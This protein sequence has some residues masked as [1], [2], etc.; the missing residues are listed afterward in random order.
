M[1][2][3]VFEKDLTQCNGDNTVTLFG[4]LYS[5]NFTKKCLVSNDGEVH[6]LD[7]SKDQLKNI[8]NFE[9]NSEIK[10]AWEFGR[11]T[12]LIDDFIQAERTTSKQNEK[13]SE[14]FIR[15]ENWL[16]V[17]SQKNSGYDY[18]M[19]NAVR[20]ISAIFI[21]HYVVRRCGNTSNILLDG[22][23]DLIR[24]LTIHV[25]LDTELSSQPGNH[26]HTQLLSIKLA[27]EFFGSKFLKWIVQ[28]YNK[29][30]INDIL[31]QFLDDG[32]SIEGSF[33]YNKFMVDVVLVDLNIFN[34]CWKIKIESNL[35]LREK[36]V[37]I[38]SFYNEFV[39]P[40]GNNLG[41]CD[42]SHL[43]PDSVGLDQLFI[44]SGFY[45]L[46]H[47]SV[48]EIKRIQRLPK[49]VV[50]DEFGVVKVSLSNPNLSLF[51]RLFSDSFYGKGGHARDDGMAIWLYVDNE[52]VVGTLGTP[53]YTG[54]LAKLKFYK[55]QE[56]QSRP[57]LENSLFCQTSGPWRMQN[58]THH[59]FDLNNDESSC[60][61]LTLS[62]VS[63]DGS[64]QVSRSVKLHE[65]NDYWSIYI[66]DTM[67]SLV[68]DNFRV[69]IHILNGFDI[70]DERNLQYNRKDIQV[71]NSVSI[72]FNDKV[73]SNI[74]PAQYYPSFQKAVPAQSIILSTPSVCKLRSSTIDWSIYVKKS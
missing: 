18:P 30:V 61:N 33:G 63:K 51:L 65:C 34:K 40:L 29:I 24:R 9:K 50:A 48:P 32:G 59:T 68:P 10:V 5:W 16:C 7:L 71:N 35:A 49:T 8:Y 52:L 37:S 13:Y 66:S 64:Y 2:I 72:S 28:L 60:C 12:W 46:S 20:L 25:V 39:V 17:I 55:S 70:G 14:V 58:V 31:D 67:S 43:L 23:H 57:V 53:C 4:N 6:S 69:L 36:L 27:S 74:E 62:H 26:Y 3:D 41:D 21:Y 19:E 47:F 1:I 11:G 73:R 38:F 44:S 42:G 56:C 15:L 22:L 54:N 45:D